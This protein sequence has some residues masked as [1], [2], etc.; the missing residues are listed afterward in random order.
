MLHFSF[1]GTKIQKQYYLSKV[2]LH[3]LEGLSIGWFVG[4]EVFRLTIIIHFYQVDL[5]VVTFM[6][7]LHLFIFV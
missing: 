1:N 4:V 5:A 7:S 2:F 3:H 6:Q